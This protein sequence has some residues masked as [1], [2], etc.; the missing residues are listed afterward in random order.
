LAAGFGNGAVHLTG[1]IFK[2]AKLDNAAGERLSI[3]DRVTLLDTQ[4]DE[5]AR[6]DPGMFL[7]FNDNS[8]SGYALND[9]S[10]E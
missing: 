5:N 7:S 10:H 8:G 3:F 4:Q 1:L 6:A 2:D 9:G